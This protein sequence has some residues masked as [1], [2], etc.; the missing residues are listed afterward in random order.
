MLAPFTKKIFLQINYRI[1]YIALLIHFLL[2]FVTSPQFRFFLPEFIFFSVIITAELFISLKIKWKTTSLFL[3]FMIF[4]PLLIFEFINFGSL[5]GNPLHQE[6]SKFSW[7]QIVIPEKTSKYANVTFEKIK[8]GNM[9]YYSPQQNFFFYGT[10]NGPLP[11]VNKIQLDYFE[12]K[13]GIKPQLRGT[14]LKDGF[15][16][17]KTA[18]K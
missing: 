13:M 6:K 9:E 2:L 3:V 18:V 8:N 5:T 10:A 11:C 1:A 15:Y 16:S 14:S 4:I 12:K 17:L 7:I